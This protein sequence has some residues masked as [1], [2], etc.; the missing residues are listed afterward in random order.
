[1]VRSANELSSSM[2]CVASTARLPGPLK[3]TR[4]TTETSVRPQAMGNPEKRTTSVTT[5]MRRPICSSFMAQAPCPEIGG[6][7]RLRLFVGTEEVGHVLQRGEPE[8]QGHHG[9]EGPAQRVP[10]RAAVLVG[11]PCLHRQ[12]EPDPREVKAHRETQHGEEAGQD[13]AAPGREPFRDE[14]DAD[15]PPGLE[16]VGRAHEDRGHDEV[17]GELDLP[18]G[19][20]AE[21]RD[22]PPSTRR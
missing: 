11:V 4:K 2:N 9:E 22:R 14:V 19:R 15:V 3:A 6:R 17:G 1:M 7:G 18:V 12:G 13:A 16:A 10:R 20:I 21:R 5:M 8:P